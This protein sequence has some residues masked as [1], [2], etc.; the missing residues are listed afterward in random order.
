M[1]PINMLSNDYKTDQQILLVIEK[2]DLQGWEWLYDKYSPVMF[3]LIQ[4]FTINNEQAEEILLNTFLKI[5]TDK[6][7]LFQK[8]PLIGIISNFTVTN[9][10]LFLKSNKI[11]PIYKKARN[12][13]FPILN[14]LLLDQK[15]L[16]E[17]SELFS[18]K[19][20]EIQIDLRS[21]LKVSSQKK[22]SEII[23]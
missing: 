10:K 6:P 8:K 1:L 19:K 9:T 18:I 13:K 15:S 2:D 4:F 22:L 23:L 17:T 11:F 12:K 21:E 14:A 3:G 7:I 5:T 16:T 20:N